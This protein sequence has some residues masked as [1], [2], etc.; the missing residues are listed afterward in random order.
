[1]D[2][3]IYVEPSVLD[4][5][6]AFTPNGD[7]MNDRFMVYSKS[8]RFVS[9]EIYSQSGLKVYGFSGE[10]DVLEN[11]KG[12]DGNI[13]NS[14]VKASVGIYYYVI[15]ALGWDDINYNSKKYTGFVY[16]YR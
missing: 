2:S 15:R 12:W 8:L 10:G 3:L 14:S 11:W 6:N 1:M 13:N 4:I 5:P 7:G 9:M 16:L